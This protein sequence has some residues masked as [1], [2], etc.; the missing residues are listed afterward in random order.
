VPDA[1]VPEGSGSG[2]RTIRLP[3]F[4]DRGVA[5][6]VCVWYRTV[7]GSAT[8]AD[9][10]ATGDG[11]QDFLQLG[12]STLKAIRIPSRRVAGN[13]VMQVAR[14]SA[15]EGDETFQIEVLKVTRDPWGT[16]YSSDFASAPDP[17]FVLAQAVG[18]VTIRDDDG[19]T[20]T[21][22]LRIGDVGWPEDASVPSSPA[23]LVGLS[24]PVNQDL[25]LWVQTRDGSA[26]GVDDW[27]Q[28]QYGDTTDFLRV[29]SP[30]PVAFKLRANTTEKS[31]RFLSPR[32]VFVR[33]D[34]IPEPNETLDVVV[35]KVTAAVSGRCDLTS[36]SYAGVS[37]AEASGRITIYDDDTPV[38]VG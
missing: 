4:F 31:L 26:M 34:V 19:Q 28:L 29:G 6:P 33:D 22:S 13:F 23:M 11:S 14:D 15:V 32:R 5:H 17:A 16:C 24:R 8:G 7:N 37:I 18:T 10:L 25:C 2:R 35:T 27:S 9:K 21:A 38:A 3:F 20:D 12:A 1:S 30:A 36:P